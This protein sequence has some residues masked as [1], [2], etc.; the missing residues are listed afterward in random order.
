M[1]I[2]RRKRKKKALCISMDGM[3]ES[4]GSVVEEYIAK[5]SGLNW[6]AK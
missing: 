6:I 5:L 4:T 1:R 2:C 3:T